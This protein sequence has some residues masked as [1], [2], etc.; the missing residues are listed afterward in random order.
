MNRKVNIHLPQILYF[1]VLELKRNYG[2]LSKSIIITVINSIIYFC[3]YYFFFEFFLKSKFSNIDNS[4]FN[5]GIFLYS[6]LIYLFFFTGCTSKAGIILYDKLPLISK[7]NFPIVIF[8]FVILFFNYFY[9]IIN[10]IILFIFVSY[11]HSFELQILFKF[12]IFSIL[13]LPVYLAIIYI[14]IFLSILRKNIVHFIQIINHSILF[15]SPVFYV[16]E[17]IQNNFKIILY[18]N[19]L[20][21]IINSF[22]DLMKNQI[23][24]NNNFLFLIFMSLIL[25]FIL[26]IFLKKKRYYIIEKIISN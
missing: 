6:G 15:F 21:Y 26:Y 11:F 2:S 19:P 9:L 22:R 12:T 18:F 13:I 24:T 1:T 14:I 4:E 10:L 25:N 23:F 5:S 3:V 17:Q 8:P 20:F 7:V 16:A